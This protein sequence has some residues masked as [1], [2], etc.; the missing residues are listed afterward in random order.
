[1]NRRNG[2]VVLRH[3]VA[4]RVRTMFLL[5]HVGGALQCYAR[6]LVI[7]F[8]R[9]EQVGGP[10]VPGLLRR[11]SAVRINGDSTRR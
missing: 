5:S 3:E 8:R 11:A 7:K 1:M 2:G 4:T 10:F 6:L 9:N